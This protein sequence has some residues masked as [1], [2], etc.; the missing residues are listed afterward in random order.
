MMQN[1]AYGQ[2]VSADSPIL[3]VTPHSGTHIPDD[4]LAYPAWR[5]VQGRV[6][7]P[8]GIGMHA[9]AQRCGV[10]CVSARY[11][12]C[13][14]DFNVPTTDRPLSRSL[15]RIGLCRTHTARGDALYPPGCEPDDAQIAAR[16]EAYWR[17]FHEVVAGEVARLRARHENV[18]MLTFHASFWL[19]PYRDRFEASDC[20]VG[21]A[22]GRSCDR[23]LVSCLTEQIKAQ[24]HS[25]V[26]NGKIA[27]VFAAEHYGR[28]E[29]G[30]H[31][32]EIEVAGR[33]RAEAERRQLGEEGGAPP[34]APAAMFGALE[35]A[36]RELGPARGAMGLATR[37][38]G[39][40]D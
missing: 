35:E 36:L 39:G 37:V 25:W 32:M 38:H 29:D 3:V 4:L 13:V 26:V 33:W 11:H 19:S 23:R 8:V 22:R 24:G 28:P 6:A 10:S 34:H 9:L 5:D 30:I 1:M 40:A 2:I 7:D 20:N 21:T 17:P 14:I 12:P 18:L 31:A 15:S 16:I 27:D